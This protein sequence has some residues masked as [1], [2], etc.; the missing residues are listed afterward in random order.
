M[1]EGVIFRYCESF[2]ADATQWTDDA[3]S[4]V[5]LYVLSRPPVGGICNNQTQFRRYTASI[6]VQQPV[7]MGPTVW[8]VHVYHRGKRIPIALWSKDK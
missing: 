8:K 4:V 5:S 6:E 3:R 7:E 2:F 1:I